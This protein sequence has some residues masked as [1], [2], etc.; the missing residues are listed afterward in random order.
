MM[1]AKGQLDTRLANFLRN[2]RQVRNGQVDAHD[3]TKGDE[4]LP[5]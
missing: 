3:C 5:E 1:N 2:S 4:A